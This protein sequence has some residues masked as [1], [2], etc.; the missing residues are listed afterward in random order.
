MFD[1]FLPPA[2][3][4]TSIAI[5]P[6]SERVQVRATTYITGIHGGIII[7]IVIVTR[8]FRGFGVS[9]PADHPTCIAI[10]VNPRY[11]KED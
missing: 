8:C 3:H 6:L 4:P 9:P 2:D 5:Q 11:F 1:R 10:R 7:I